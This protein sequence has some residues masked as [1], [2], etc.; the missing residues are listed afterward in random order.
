MMP[1]STRA[2][3]DSRNNASLLSATYTLNVPKL[4]PPT[5][6]ATVPR[7]DV[8]TVYD[9]DSAAEAVSVPFSLMATEPVIALPPLGTT[10]PTTSSSPTTGTNAVP[11]KFIAKLPTSDPPLKGAPLCASARPATTFEVSIST[12]LNAPLICGYTAYRNV[13]PPAVTVTV[14]LPVVGSGTL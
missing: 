5:F 1:T 9:P 6:I 7:P 13:R 12:T 8:A 4:P 11:V 2:P 10:V 14:V 3:S